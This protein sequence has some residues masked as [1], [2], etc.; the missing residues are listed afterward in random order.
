MV[1]VLCLYLLSDCCQNIWAID[2]DV[3]HILLL[4]CQILTC[5]VLALENP[6]EHNL[7]LFNEL[8]YLYEPCLQRP[9]TWVLNI[10]Q[11]LK[12]TIDKHITDKTDKKMI[13]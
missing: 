8:Q 6:K 4:V 2:F 5:V 3:S 10:G 11:N 13:S 9:P 1:K 12:W 7:L